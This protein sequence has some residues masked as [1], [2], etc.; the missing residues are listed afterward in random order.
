MLSEFRWD[1]SYGVS[2][3]EGVLTPALVLYPD[4]IRKH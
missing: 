4:L 3:V 1:P 2:N